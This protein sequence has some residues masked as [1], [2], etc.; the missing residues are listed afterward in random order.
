MNNAITI[1]F[2]E[3]YFIC[4]IQPNE[5]AWEILRV[6]ASEKVPLYFYVNGS[7]IRNDDFAK[8]RFISKS[9]DKNT[10]GNFYKII[11]DG[12]KTFRRFEI[13][14]ECI[15]LLQDS[16]E[17]LKSAYAERIV[18]F[19]P[20]LS[21]IQE[22]PA[23]ICFVPGVSVEAQNKIIGYFEER[24]FAVQNTA[25]YFES[26]LKILQRKGLIPQKLNLSI[27]DTYFGDMLFHYIEYDAGVKKYACET[28]VGKG[29]DHR[30]GNLA[31]LIV[32][33]AA[34]RTSSRLLDDR[35]R[36]LFDEEV[37]RF[38]QTA[39]GQINNFEYNQ[40]DI[41]VELSDF[42]TARVIID[43]RELEKMSSESFQFIKYKYESFIS[44]HSNLART[45]K[46]LLN[47]SVLAADAFIRFFESSFGTP[48]IIKPFPNFS[49]LLSR[50]VFA[51]S[52]PKEASTE[53]E[54]EIKITVVKKPPIPG[55]PP[56]VKAPD[57]PAKP[58]VPA[59][60][61]MPQMPPPKTN[62]LQKL[63]GKTGK[64]LSDLNPE[65]RVEIDGKTY[66]AY[67]HSK[68]IKT[69]NE[70]MVEKVRANVL[71]VGKYLSP[72]PP[73]PPRPPLPSKK[74]N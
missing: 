58:Q 28:L 60:P 7:D 34:R 2:F 61:K 52:Q 31:K 22:I 39:A 47:G 57:L 66:L 68:Q 55:M 3:D 29:V 67:N 44:K 40:L 36:N 8:D 63:I 15:T 70:I 12:E 24:G 64:A 50:G 25:G 69:G 1:L 51:M 49:E 4:S 37:K 23:N 46:I 16:L 9:E 71:E 26:F 42:S 19:I 62:E 65:G 35:N 56:K 30:I 21:G 32:E 20:E 27:V 43:Q 73:L 5:S 38:H 53:E 17:H 14:Y 13:E 59:T 45:E 33:K 48:K 10:F 18:S 72:S 41:K 11:L 74:K 6:N 54:I